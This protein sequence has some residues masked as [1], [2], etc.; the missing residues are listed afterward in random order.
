MAANPIFRQIVARIESFGGEEF[1]FDELMGGSTLAD[2][3]RIMDVTRGQL[4]KW[5]HKDE[6]RWNAYLQAREIGAHAMV[7]EARDILDEATAHSIAVDRERARIR[8][9]VAER[10]NRGEFG[11]QTPAQG[12]LVLSIGELHLAAVQSGDAPAILPGKSAVEDA[13]FEVVEDEPN[14]SD[15]LEPLRCVRT[16]IPPRCVPL[17]GGSFWCHP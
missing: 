8:Q 13:D 12:S 11:A 14:L 1:V 4:Y 6:E 3:G 5:M 2:L 17:R 15:L 16:Q 10:A 7:D 9:W